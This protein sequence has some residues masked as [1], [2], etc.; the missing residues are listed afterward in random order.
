MILLSALLLITAAWW[1]LALWPVEAAPVWLERTRYVC[2][3]VTANGLPDAGGWI[4]LIFGPLGMLAI[5]VAGWGGAI[6]SL[7]GRARSSRAVA[8]VLLVLTLGVGV[9]AAGAAIRVRQVSGAGMVVALD[10][11]VPSPTLPRMD[12]P[13][14]RLGLIDQ[15]GEPLELAALAGQPALV[16][17]AFAHCETIC[18]LLVRN[19][20]EARAALLEEGIATNVVVVTLDPWRDRPSRLPAIAAGWGLPDAGAWLLSGPVEAVEAVLDAWEVPRSRDTRTGEVTH[21][22]LTWVI[23]AEGRIAYAST[24]GTAALVSLVRRL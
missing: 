16:T 4:G 5:L 14:P 9:L 24:G 19:A 11:L 15:R 7:A 6:R 18:P 10:D 17:F 3:G 12:W 23:D 8:A 22:S 1:A 21:P 2:F 13:A 20:L